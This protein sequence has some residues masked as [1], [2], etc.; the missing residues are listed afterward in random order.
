MAIFSLGVRFRRAPASAVRSGLIPRGTS[1]L[2][3]LDSSAAS[4]S[5]STFV[6]L[7]VGVKNP[8]WTG[9]MKPLT[10]TTTPKWPVMTRGSFRVTAH[11]R[12]R[13]TGTEQA[14]PSPD[15][16]VVLETAHSE[17]LQY[18]VASRFPRNCSLSQPVSKAWKLPKNRF[19][20]YLLVREWS[21]RSVLRFVPF[22]SVPVRRRRGFGS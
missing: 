18:Q 20:A 13:I 2:A 19:A 15:K 22:R 16:L 10:M 6:P 5:G 17:V 11:V 14:D 9:H 12:V 8:T 3:S 4:T 1:T 7:K 21:F